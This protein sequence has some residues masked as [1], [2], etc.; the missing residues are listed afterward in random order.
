MVEKVG[1]RRSRRC[2]FRLAQLASSALILHQAAPP[3]LM[4]SQI[5]KSTEP[6]NPFP[7]S[8]R[9]F[10]ICSTLGDLNGNFH[11]ND[12][13]FY[14]VLRAGTFYSGTFRNLLLTDRLGDQFLPYFSTLSR[15]IY[16][17]TTMG[18]R[19]LNICDFFL[20]Y[21]LLCISSKE[22]DQR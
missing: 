6:C 10:F 1:E 9:L 21:S 7:P 4:D 12:W 17:S 2:K 11:P 5:S 18:N 8:R 22:R 15:V 13:S 20:Y 16:D 3:R 19:L 14:K